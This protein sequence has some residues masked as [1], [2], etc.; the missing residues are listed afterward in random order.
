MIFFFS[1]LLI[2]ISHIEN[3]LIADTSEFLMNII[4]KYYFLSVKYMKI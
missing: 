3:P 1:I 4:L 2:I